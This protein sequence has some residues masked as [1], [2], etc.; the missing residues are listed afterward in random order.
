MGRLFILKIKSLN[1][2]GAETRSLYIINA[3]F[4][5]ANN[6]KYFS[7]RL[8]NG[9]STIAPALFYYLPSMA[10]CVTLLT[11]FLP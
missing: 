3:G 4:G 7:Q 9:S 10:E 1:H 11:G 8:D 5:A 6:M 2:R